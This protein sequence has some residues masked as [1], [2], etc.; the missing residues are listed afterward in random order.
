MSDYQRLIVHLGY[1]KTAST[2]FQKRYYPYVENATYIPRE[3]ILEALCK[4]YRFDYDP[5]PLL[6]EIH[7]CHSD[8][9]IL[10]HEELSG[11][12]HS[13]GLNGH[14]SRFVADE[15][16]RLFPDCHVVIFIRHQ[17]S[18]IA[19][20]YRQYVKEGGTYSVDHY[21]HHAMDDFRYR[22]P[23]F[24]WE[25]LQYD[26]LIR[27][28]IQ[29][30]G[31]SRVHVF[32]FEA[33][34]HDIPQFLDIFEAALGL[35]ASR[36]Q[37][38]FSESNSSNP[39]YTLGLQRWLNQFSFQNVGYKRVIMPLNTSFMHLNDRVKRHRLLRR[40]TKRLPI[41]SKKS[42]H[43][44]LGENNVQHIQQYYAPSNQVLVDELGLD[45]QK[46]DYP[47]LG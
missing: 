45:L 35:S 39:D 38:D 1:H 6:Q 43:H 29:L 13:G 12:I 11:N 19:S 22:H 31:R 33:F 26:K 37:I 42:A 44:L 40:I 5:A 16:V 32:L 28:Y 25:H 8:T 18:M 20:C 14:L 34:K 30:L 23:L 4:P 7:K 9:V 27:Y 15:I 47:L 21:L 46:Y 3:Y 24:I 2:W 17:V 10:S 41:R 36:E